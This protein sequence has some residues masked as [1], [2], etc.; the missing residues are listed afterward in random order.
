MRGGRRKEG[1][2]ENDT[3]TVETGGAGGVRISVKH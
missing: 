2:K 1:K 3:S